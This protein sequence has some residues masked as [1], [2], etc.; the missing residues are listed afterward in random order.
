MYKHMG[1]TYYSKYTNRMLICHQSQ[2]KNVKEF[3]LRQ[4][5]V[6]NKKA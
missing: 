5:T 2:I 3:S 4:A 6:A 1:T